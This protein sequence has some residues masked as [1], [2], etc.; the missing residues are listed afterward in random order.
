MMFKKRLWASAICISSVVALMGLVG[1]TVAIPSSTVTISTTT[2]DYSGPDN[3]GQWPVFYDITAGSESYLWFTESNVNEIFRISPKTGNI[4]DIP[5]PGI[6]SIDITSGPDGNLWFTEWGGNKIGEISPKTGIITAYDIPIGDSS[7]NGITTGPDGNIWFTEG[8]Q[9]LAEGDVDSIGKITPKTG[10]VTEYNIPT[11]EAEPTGI[12]VGPDGNLWFTEGLGNKIG[13][14][15]P[16]T[17]NITEY[18]LPTADSSPQDISHGFLDILMEA[19]KEAIFE[20]V[21]EQL[22]TKLDKPKT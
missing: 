10:N 9:L 12:T 8:H 22:N 1:C 21:Q 20:L 3:M 5:T 11:T 17:G 2:A 6:A 18:S 14:I 15:S 16:A 13:K 19:T 4:T 7:P